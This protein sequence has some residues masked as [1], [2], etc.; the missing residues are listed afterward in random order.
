MKKV[1]VF[2][3]GWGHRWLM[4]TLADNGIEAIFEY[5]PE[6]L[7]RGLELS[8]LNLALRAEAY[9]N[10]PAHLSRLPGLL[11]DSLPDG[12]GLL[13]M[14]KLF[15]KSGRNLATIS[16]LDRLSFIGDRAIGALSF[17][18]GDSLKLSGSDLSLR[19]CDRRSL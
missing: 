2:F 16:S 8:P 19:S 5:S 9:G 18:P 15:L 6:A 17:Q 7:K 1:D 14:D 11:S 10:F 3:C 12:W 4:G 13:L